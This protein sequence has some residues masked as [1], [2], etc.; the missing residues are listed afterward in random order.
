MS[1][2][3]L[4]RYI[5]SSLSALLLLRGFTVPLPP[6]PSPPPH[7]HLGDI[8]RVSSSSCR[9]LCRIGCAPWIPL[10]I[11][12]SCRGHFPSAGGCRLSEW[13]PHFF[14]PPRFSSFS[15]PSDLTEPYLHGDTGGYLDMGETM[16]KHSPSRMCLYRLKRNGK[17]GAA[18]IPQLR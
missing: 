7:A 13:P 1:R 10:R 9:V 14:L 15:L 11:H 17:M 4:H 12:V 6:L 5:P 16:G 3:P 18:C 8:N 2:C